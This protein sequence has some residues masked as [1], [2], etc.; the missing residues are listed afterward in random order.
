MESDGT[1][2]YQFYRTTQG[3]TGDGMVKGWKDN[4]QPANLFAVVFRE[5]VVLHGQQVRRLT[6]SIHGSIPT[7]S[8]SEDNSFRRPRLRFGLVCHIVCKLPRRMSNPG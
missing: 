4:V 2:A 3:N 7:R 8:A 1:L 6:R 5:K